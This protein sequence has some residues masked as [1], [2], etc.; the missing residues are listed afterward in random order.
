MNLNDIEREIS[1]GYIT[2]RI[3]PQNPDIIIL[4]YTEKAIYD[5]HWNEVTMSCRGLIINEKTGEV[6][7][8]P[9]KKFFNHNEDVPVDLSIPDEKP[10]ATIKHDGSLGILYRLNN[11]IYWTTRGSFESEQ[12]KLRKIFGRKDIKM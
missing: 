5:K 3:H 1:N 7:A 2:K 4:N 12:A 9:F 6:L 8:R 11:Q 10:V